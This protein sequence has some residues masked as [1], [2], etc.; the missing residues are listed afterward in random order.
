MSWFHALKPESLRDLLIQEVKCTCDIQEQQVK[1]LDKLACACS[2]GELRCLNP[3]TG[4]RVWSTRQPTTGGPEV[5]W[6]NVF[7]TPH[8]G[9]ATDETRDAMGHTALDNIAAVL[10]GAAPPNPVTG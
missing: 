7:L 3:Q 6:A 4:E 5:R 10:R 2:D 8:M 1:A 9:S